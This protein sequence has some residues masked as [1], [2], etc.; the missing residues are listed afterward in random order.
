MWI[1]TCQVVKL[2]WQNTLEWL[3]HV[4]SQYVSVIF[5]PLFLETIKQGPT[6]SI[7][8]KL[9]HLLVIHDLGGI[10]AKS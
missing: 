5:T 1:I 2:A 4:Y 6:T 7:C 10:S 9:S 3:E 8:S